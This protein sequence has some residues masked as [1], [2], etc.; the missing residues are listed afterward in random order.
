MASHVRLKTRPYTQVFFPNLGL[1]AYTL[2]LPALLT[3]NCSR[4]LL[5][6]RGQETVPGGCLACTENLALACVRTSGPH[7]NRGPAE[8]VILIE[9]LDRPFSAADV[10]LGHIREELARCDIFVRHNVVVRWIT[11]LGEL[12]ARKPNEA[13]VCVCV[14]VPVCVCLC[15]RACLCTCAV[16]TWWFVVRA[17]VSAGHVQ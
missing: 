10:A 4:D 9:R 13:C 14:R 7:F 2:Q 1:L 6:E 15:V 11:L 16:G 5:E 8:F 3:C 12:C 17:G